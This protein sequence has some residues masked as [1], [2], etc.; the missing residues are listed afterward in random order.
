MLKGARHCK[1]AKHSHSQRLAGKINAS[2][3]VLVRLLRKLAT[4]G[5]FRFHPRL[6][7]RLKIQLSA[8]VL[9]IGGAGPAALVGTAAGKK[10]LVPRRWAEAY[11]QGGATGKCGW[12]RLRG[13]GFFPVVGWAERG[14]G[15]SK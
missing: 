12:L 11:V 4:T 1:P 9:T 6:S 15:L 14:G 8:D 13:I 10:V 3:F 5:D 2:D 7:Y